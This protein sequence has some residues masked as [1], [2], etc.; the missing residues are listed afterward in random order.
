[1]MKPT[2]DVE[3]IVLSIQ[4]YKESDGLVKVLTQ[5]GIIT[6]L[7]K[8][9]QKQT[10]KNRSIV[11]P[12]TKGKYTID[13]RNGLSLLYYGQTISYYY[14]I[15]EDLTISSLCFLLSECITL[16]KGKDIYTIFD[17][18][19]EC[20][21][22]GDMNGYSYACYILKTILIQQ[23]IAPYVDG[24]ILCQRKDHLETLSINDGGFLCTTCNH[25]QYAARS[26]KEMIQF[27]SLMKVKEDDLNRFLETYD[28]NLDDCIYLATWF[29][30]YMNVT[31]NSLTFLKSVRSFS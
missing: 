21:Q 27:Y 10:S 5:E 31:L 12:F 2:K 24:C 16:S 1:M 30:K 29:E 13:E 23:G 11:Q 18:C 7:A 9:I 14:R 22:N 28:F 25:G 19:L 4:D 17:T 15:H 3:G 26:K 20:F 8:G 6:L